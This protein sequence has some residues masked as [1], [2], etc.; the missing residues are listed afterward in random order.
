MNVKVQVAMKKPKTDKGGIKTK[1]DY[2]ELTEEQFEKSNKWSDVDWNLVERKVYKLQKR[3]YKASQNGDVKKVRQLQKTLMRSWS[4]KLLAVRRVTQDNKGKKTAGIDGVKSIHTYKRFDLAKNLKLTGKAKPTRRVWIPKPNKKDEKRPLGIPTIADRALQAIVKIVLEP[5]WEA[6][7]EP[8][9]Y[10]FRPGRSCHDAI[11]AIY[12]AIHLK[13]KF[14]L[15]ADIA[16]C[17]DKIDHDKLLQKINTFPTLRKQIKAWLKAGAIDENNYEDTDYGTPQGGVISPL[18]ANIALHGMEEEVKKYAETIKIKGIGKINKRR[19][20]ALIR[21]ADDFVILHEYLDV[22]KDTKI[23]IENWLKDIG[24]ELNQKKTKISH[25]LDEYEGN[26]GF[27]FLGFNVRQYP[28]GKHHSGKNAHGKLLGFKT[29]IKPSKEKVKLH[30]DKL[31]EIIRGHKSSPQVALISK[32]NPVI[33]GWCNYYSSTVSKETFSKLSHLTYLKLKRWAER[34]HPNKSKTWV[35]GKYWHSVKTETKDRN[36][37]FS[38]LKDGQITSQLFNH[39]DTPIVR[40]TKVKD[41]TSPFNGDW[42]YWATR[43]GEHP[44]CAKQVAE[45]IKVQ[46]GK[47]PHCNLYFTSEDTLEIDHII[48]TSK[49]G[50]NIKENRQ[51]LHRHCHDVKTS[52]DGSNSRKKKDVPK[53]RGH[54]SEKPCEVKVSSTVLFALAQPPP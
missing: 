33:R 34:R 35:A 52:Q 40:H 7:F 47:C 37:V 11:E 19:S 4:A 2:I 6:K 12:S 49:G 30:S 24:L 27:N 17:F 44:E 16:K 39:A 50:K 18:L 26:K 14:V 25:T 13:P 38:S 41:I 28:I 32:L 8:N 21:Y 20:I 3:I 45:L 23:I 54:S 10:G 42:V 36:W 15:D 22:I 46:K 31:K 9:S 43:R 1:S 53:D 29:L 48:P 51:L 5:E